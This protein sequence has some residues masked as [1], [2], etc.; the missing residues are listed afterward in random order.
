MERGMRG[1]CRKVCWGVKEVRGDVGKGEV[2]EE[3][4]EVCWGPTPSTFPYTS[5]I[6]LPTSFPHAPIHFPTPLP[7][8][9]IHSPT[10]LHSPHIFSY[11]PHTLTHFPT[12]PLTSPPTSSHSYPDLPLHPNTLPHLPHAL[13]SHLSPQF[14][15]CGEVTI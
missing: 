6:P 3:M 14:R 4:W 13:S 15:L 2:R 12:P 7:T 1:R 11:L 9:P 5:P 8:H 10:L